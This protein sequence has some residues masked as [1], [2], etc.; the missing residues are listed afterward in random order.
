MSRVMKHALGQLLTIAFC[1]TTVSA[2][3]PAASGFQKLQSLAG[4]W[5]G[6]D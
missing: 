3:S 2:A 1:V 6:K 4:R 5:E